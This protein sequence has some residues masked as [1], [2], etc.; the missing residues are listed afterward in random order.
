M[1][2]RLRNDNL[3]LV[4]VIECVSA[5]GVLA[6]TSFVLKEGKLKLIRLTSTTDHRFDFFRVAFSP[7]G[8]TDGELCEQWFLKT[9]IPVA[10]SCRVS[11]KPIIL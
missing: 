2:Y 1:R 4:T 6:P 3:E 8:W 5:A 11:D 7:N 9:F 10:E